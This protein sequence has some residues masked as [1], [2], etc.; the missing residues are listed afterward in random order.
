MTPHHRE[1]AY[2]TG[3]AIEAVAADPLSAAVAVARDF[4]TV[5]ALK[6]VRTVVVS[7]DGDFAWFEGGNSGLATSGSGDVLAGI[8]AGIGARGADSFAAAGW[9]VF[10][11]GTAGEKAAVALAPIGFL[12]HEL[13][14]FIPR[15]LSDLTALSGGADEVR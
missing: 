12:A 9:G 15:L 4:G 8:I 13:L 11:H 7:A 5:V 6:G 3:L 1:M 14:P 10:V 2:L